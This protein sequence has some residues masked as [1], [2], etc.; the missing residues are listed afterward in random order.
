[1]QGFRWRK[2]RSSK[3]VLCELFAEVRRIQAPKNGSVVLSVVM[4]HGLN[5]KRS[6]KFQAFQG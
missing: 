4:S 2:Q 5:V 3:S 1:M 6:A